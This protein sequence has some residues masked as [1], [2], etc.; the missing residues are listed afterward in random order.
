MRISSKGLNLIKTFEGLKLESYQCQAGV[1][2]IGYG[3]T[4]KVTKG[5][6]ITEEQA[7]YYLRQDVKTVTVN[8]DKFISKHNLSL[9]Q[10]QYDALCSFIFNVGYGNFLSSSIC[11]GLIN[12]EPIENFPKYFSL[13]NK[14]RVNGVLTVSNGLI[15]RRKSEASLF[16]SK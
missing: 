1:W 8:L 13:W 9:N 10:N 4:H 16:I 11:K 15:K 2:T 5:M 3:H 14:V 12:K 7:D 6:K